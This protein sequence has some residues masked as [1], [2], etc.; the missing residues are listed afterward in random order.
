MAR[1]EHSSKSEELATMAEVRSKEKGIPYAVALKEISRE[2]PGLADTARRE[3]LGGKLRCET[4]GDPVGRQTISVVDLGQRLAE[5]AET[6]SREKNIPYSVAL[7]EIGCE[8][9]ELAHGAR[10]ETLGVRVTPLGGDRRAGAR[11]ANSGRAGD[12]IMRMAERRASEKNISYQS[13]LSEVSREH[14]ELAGAAR[15]E[16]LGIATKAKDTKG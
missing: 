15:Q 3:A 11:D 14:P 13:A 16:A 12:E 6:R 9:R 2:Y 5:M 4:V 1:E 8:Y 10:E 7:S